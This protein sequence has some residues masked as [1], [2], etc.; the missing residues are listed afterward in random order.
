MSRKLSN[1]FH[2]AAGTVI[3]KTSDVLS[4]PARARSKS[5]IARS[6]RETKILKQARAGK[7]APQ[8][9]KGKPTQA[10]KLQTAAEA[11]RSR[12]KKKK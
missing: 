4:A 5:K 9:H 3:E 12:H 8:F 1:I 2:K 11:I 7:G 6:T 10:F